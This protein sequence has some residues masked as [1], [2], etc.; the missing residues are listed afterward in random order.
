M[1]P[2]R[3]EFLGWTAAAAATT[4]AAARAATA[5]A[6]ASPIIDTHVHLWEPAKQRLL[7]LEKGSELDRNA[8]WDD[9]LKAAAGLDVVKAVYMEVDVDPSQHEAEARMVLDQCRK[10]DTALCA[11][12]IGGRPAFEGFAAYIEPLAKDPAVKGVRQVLHGPPT[13]AGYCLQEAFVKGVRRLGELGLCFDLCMRHA[14]LADGAKLI[15]QATGTR[16]VLDH[17]GNPP[18]FGD[19]AA[20]K[21][22]VDRIAALPNV[23]GKVSGIVASAKGRSWKADDLAPVIHHM[24]EAFGPDRVMFGGDWPVCTLG[25]PLRDWVNALSEIVRDRKAEDQR[26]L[27]HDNAAK[28]YR[29]V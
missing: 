7:W 24:I 5:A 1:T 21:R 17:C 19:L 15:E 8:L 22:D 18:V 14:E 9:Y 6:P 12:V 27:F 2:T 10:G 26:K 16:F 29:L 11:A 25:A 3:R 28:F 13:P 4:T 23:V 20:W